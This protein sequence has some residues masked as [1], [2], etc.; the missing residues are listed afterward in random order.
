MFVKATPKIQK[1]TICYYCGKNGHKSYICNDRLRKHSNKVEIKTKSNVPLMTKKIKQI[2]VPK[3]TNL[4]KIVV[5]K[6][7]W[8]PKLT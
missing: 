7:T 3:G 6:K 1:S 8:V 2:L 5:S 4:R